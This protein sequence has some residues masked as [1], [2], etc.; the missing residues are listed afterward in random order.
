[1]HN[2]NIRLPEDK[3]KLIG[4]YMYL[5]AKLKGL[6]EEYVSFVESPYTTD[7][8]FLYRIVFSEMDFYEGMRI[9][10]SEKLPESTLRRLRN[11]DDFSGW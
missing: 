7:S 6:W 5:S 1:M 10:V 3:D 9:E 4:C 11:L 8:S 2:T